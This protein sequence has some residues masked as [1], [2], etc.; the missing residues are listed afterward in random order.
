MAVTDL[1]VKGRCARSQNTKG[2]V[3]HH[4]SHIRCWFVNLLVIEWL[5]T[6][7]NKSESKQTDGKAKMM[8]RYVAFIPVAIYRQTATMSFIKLGQGRLGVPLN[9]IT[10]G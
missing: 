8:K 5:A 9:G 6:K 4:T 10:G 3:K 1:R 2:L 7:Y